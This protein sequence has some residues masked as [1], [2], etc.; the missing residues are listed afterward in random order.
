MKSM[1]AE[2]NMLQAQVNE[3]RYEI[4]RTT[5]EL[6]DTKRKFLEGRRKEQVAQERARADAPPLD[7]MT[8]Q[9]RVFLATQPRI[10]G[11][12]FNLQAQSMNATQ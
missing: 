4:E 1:A 10:T 11:G 2:L 7:P 9:Q 12:G 5:R 3:Y 6:A 8:E